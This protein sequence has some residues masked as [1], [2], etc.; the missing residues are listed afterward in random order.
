MRLRLGRWL[1]SADLTILYEAAFEAAMC[2][3]CFNGFGGCRGEIKPEL[4]GHRRSLETRF[5][6]ARDRL[7]GSPGWA[8][9]PRLVRQSIHRIF[10]T[11]YIADENLI[12]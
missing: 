1:D 2:N 5:M 3:V 9:L 12:P 8:E 11:I 10:L 7:Y 4:E 6:E